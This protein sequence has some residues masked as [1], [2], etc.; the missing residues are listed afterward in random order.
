[1]SA[2]LMDV[3]HVMSMIHLPFRLYH[4]ALQV[5]SVFQGRL[6]STTASAAAA[7]TNQTG[8]IG[9]ET[10][11]LAAMN[12]QLATAVLLTAALSEGEAV[13]AM[14]AGEA[15]GEAIVG[16]AMAGGAVASLQTG[17]TVEKTGLA[18]VHEGETF[19]GVGGGGDVHVH[20]GNITYDPSRFD[21]TDFTNP[22]HEALRTGLRGRTRDVPV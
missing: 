21:V 22:I 6:A 18:V 10:T 20:I 11:A 2:A 8:V 16:A 1:M 17:G 19:S 12:S 14:V 9:A 4:T 7:Q 5:A 3:H 15:A 13:P